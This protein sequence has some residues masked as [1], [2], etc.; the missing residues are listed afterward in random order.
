MNSKSKEQSLKNKSKLSKPIKKKVFPK[1]EAAAKK[2]KRK[3]SKK[4]GRSR[5]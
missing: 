5:K 3:T 1:K 2:S 4:V